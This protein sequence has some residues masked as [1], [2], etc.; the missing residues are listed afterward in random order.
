MSNSH[1][2]TLGQAA[3]LSQVAKSTITRAI[4]KGHLSVSQKIGNSYR[5]DPAELH[6]WQETRVQP[7][8]KDC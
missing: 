6:R 4:D 8:Q 5:I 7:Q 3:K 1:Y 2:L